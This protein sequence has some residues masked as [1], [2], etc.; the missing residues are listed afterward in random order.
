MKDEER[1]P[2]QT[3]DQ[4]PESL[5]A[6]SPDASP[7][8]GRPVSRRP[9]P[10]LLL[11]MLASVVVTLGVAIALAVAFPEE[12]GGRELAGRIGREPKSGGAPA[13]EQAPGESARNA[14]ENWETALSKVAEDILL[15]PSVSL[16]EIRLTVDVR[17]ADA[18]VD[19]VREIASALG[20]EAIESLA[21]TPGMRKLIVRLPRGRIPVFES[22]VRRAPV[23]D[24]PGDRD[25]PRSIAD[26]NEIFDV[27]LELRHDS[28]S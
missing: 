10:W 21:D 26:S 15:T 1:P 11:G 23:P 2:E 6:T 8:P 16:P 3:G 7:P 25:E 22:R 5:P 18:V 24:E 9:V 14:T 12:R 4:G 19:E 27:I 28:G 13:K 17:R 20:G